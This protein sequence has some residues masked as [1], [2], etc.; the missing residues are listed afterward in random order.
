MPYKFADIAFTPAV[1]AAQAERGSR[2]NYARF[3]QSGAANDRVTPEIAA[4]V[5]SLDGFYVGTVGSNGY[6]YV[7]FRGGDRGFLKVLDEQT[8]GFA[9]FR[10][11]RQYVTIGNLND[12]AKA[13][14]FLMDYRQ[15]RRLKIWGQAHYIEGDRD[16]INQL[17]MPDDHSPIER[18]ILFQVQAWDWNCQQHIPIRYSA[19]EVAELKTR[20]AELES[21]LAES[22][23]LRDR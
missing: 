13:I 12:N 16:L 7:Q 8:L 1:Q 5:A 23:R 18:A 15:Q 21:R 14:L 2:A 17:K 11:N 4:F 3:A 6:P 20:I 9:D 22:S 10:G 19:Q